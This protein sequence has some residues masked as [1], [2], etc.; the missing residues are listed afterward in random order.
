MLFSDDELAE[1]AAGYARVTAAGDLLGRAR[2]LARAARE[3]KRWAG[4]RFAEDEEDDFAAFADEELPL[5]A[6][7]EA[8]DYFRRLVPALGVDA[9][10]YAPRL[11]RH[12][13]TLAVASD[14]ALLNKVKAVLRARLEGPGGAADTA[15]LVREILDGAGVS[16]RNPQYADMVVRT[17]LMDSYSQG[18]TA[19]LQTPEMMDLFPAWEYHAIRDG[20]ERPHHGARDGKLYP[21]TAAFADVRGTGPADVCNCR[22][23]HS[24]VSKY[25]LRGRRVEDRW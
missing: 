22:C 20:R 24:P 4:E 9:A 13:F 16:P 18:Q 2:V 6:P 3:R 5:A 1:L 17:N 21:N 15:G 11:D 25:S 7:P 10:R 12:A 14:E 8:V 19:E 23:S